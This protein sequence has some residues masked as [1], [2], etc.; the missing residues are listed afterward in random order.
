MTKEE[1]IQLIKQIP[2]N[3]ITRI[4]RCQHTEIRIWTIRDHLKRKNCY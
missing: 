1:K 2:L 4:L 3:N